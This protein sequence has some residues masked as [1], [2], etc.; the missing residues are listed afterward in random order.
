MINRLAVVCTVDEWAKIFSLDKSEVERKLDRGY[1]AKEALGLAVPQNRRQDVEE[2]IIAIIKTHDNISR[3]DIASEYRRQYE[4]IDINNLSRYLT[5]LL[6]EGKI[7]RV[8]RG[9]YR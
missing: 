8:K 6:C 2:R 5:D 7:E 9:V 3:P 4:Y 1:T